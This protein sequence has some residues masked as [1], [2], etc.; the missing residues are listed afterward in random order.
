MKNLRLVSFL[1]IALFNGKGV[2]SQKIIFNRVSINDDNSTARITAITQ[3]PNGYMW[4]SSNG[5][6]KFDG[7]QVVHFV[8]DPLNSNS[9][10]SNQ[11]N[12]LFADQKGI[13]WIGTN[14]KGL[15]K[16]D[17]SN[18]VFTHYK[19]Q[20]KNLSS[21]NEDTITAIAKDKDNFL[22][23]GTVNGLEKLDINSGKFEHFFHNKSSN[24]LSNDYIN[25]IYVD[26]KG[27]MWIGTDGGGLNRFD[28]QTK[29]FINYQYNQSEHGS[30]ANIHALFEDSK[31]NFW[32]GFSH[33]I[34]YSMDREKGT[35][36][37]YSNN[38]SNPET[39]S[40]PAEKKSG[41]N[42]G[43]FITFIS[44][45][46][47]GGLWIGTLRS[48]I[49]R[50][51]PATHK[52]IHFESNNGNQFTDNS[53]QS[54]YSSNDGLFWISTVE[55]GLYKIDPILNTIPHYSTNGP[56]F[57]IYEDLN[58]ILWIGTSN[59]LVRTDRVSGNTQVFSYDPF[60][61]VSIS[62]NI[63]FSIYEDQQNKLWIGTDGGGLNL[64]NKATHVSVNY[65]HESQNNQSLINDVVYS[66]CEDD[67][68]NMWVGTG[69]GLDLMD[70]STGKFTHYLHDSKDTNSIGNNFIV[71]IIKDNK[72][73]IY[74]GSGY[75]GGIN[76]LI[77]SSGKFSH[78]LRGR[79]IFSLF[80][81]S[82][83]TIWAGTD[84]GLYYKKPSFA[85]F[86]EFTDSNLNVGSTA[87]ICIVE[88]PQKKLWLNSSLGI[89]E[90][91]RNRKVAGLF[92]K[93]YGLGSTN[94][95]L[96]AGYAS[97]KGELFFS[98]ND[99]YYLFDQNLLIPNLK[100]PRLMLTDF[101]LMDQ[102]VKPGTGGPLSQEINNTKELNLNY[103][104]NVFSFNFALLDYT[105]P[106]D[107][108]HFFMLENYDNGWHKS[109]TDRKAYYFNV[110][111]GHYVFH[112]KGFNSNGFGAEK[113]VDI[114]ISPPWWR[115]WW[116]YCLYV[117][118]TG[119]IV[120]WLYRNRINQLEKKQA[121][122]IK[123]MVA[124]QEDERK[125]I[126]RDLHDDVGTKLS[127]LKYFLSSL[128][129]KA[130]DSNNEEIKSLAQSSEQFITEAIQDVRQLLLNL[131]PTVLE[132][133]GYTTAVEGLVNKIN[134]TKQINFN[135][136]VFGMNRRLQKEY[137]LAL[138]RITQELINNVLKHAGA[139]HV[140]LQI[141]QRDEK[142][143]L[144][145]EDDGKGFDVN[146]HKDGYGLNNLDSRT[147]L[148][149]GTMI[150]DSK[151]GKGT[152]V[153]IEIPYNFNRT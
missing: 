114:I 130:S 109:G 88:D 94:Y 31:G 153:L 120:Y 106:E 61:L 29:S 90:L 59:G 65:R 91:D 113:K 44:E 124:T 25:S 143:I 32:I 89:I 117:L 55:G 37:E 53:G 149:Q 16:F 40:A 103:K 73:D 38:P 66:M 146:A 112:L 125:R 126:S 92:G 123:A 47:A 13:I 15:D 121:A 140:S 80:R 135:L 49:N 85:G 105:S 35:F 30:Q 8:N 84:S 99:G 2:I 74:I 63:I 75:R 101:S 19:H 115:T 56:V 79:S 104:Q 51:D 151:A 54:A 128:H 142:I 9:I 96:R 78:F 10:A 52:T 97:P 145:M 107:N 26:H 144:M 4:F 5:I 23:I 67:N 21:I 42:S 122:Q 111:P 136:V 116:A 77:R 141:G 14:G 138:Y 17:P 82:D 139:K 100:L 62:N 70:K 137:E 43:D 6:S 69:K 129:E 110:P 41:D 76:K 11:V 64:F 152:S 86:S 127:A 102:S 118:A 60:N 72:N 24:S 119:S 1:M 131:S 134:E 98:G 133:F 48:G 148:M 81:D 22:W 58:N 108:Q 20:S 46:A 50:Y 33:N 57:A 68:R 147:K 95:V 132:E 3:D 45:D 93:R 39:I 83:N 12:C 87:V 28:K 18:N 27:I 36:N 71:T 7:Y 34:L 150:I